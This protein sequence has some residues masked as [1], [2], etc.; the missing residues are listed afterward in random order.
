MGTPPLQYSG[1]R[2]GAK[3]KT[4]P[5]K[6]CFLFEEIFVIIKNEPSVRRNAAV[7]TAFC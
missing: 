4:K 3:K 1:L 5:L 6:I 2:T 7:R